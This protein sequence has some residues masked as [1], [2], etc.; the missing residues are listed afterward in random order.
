MTTQVVIYGRSHP[1]CP[2]CI[3]AKKMAEKAGLDFEYKDLTNKEWDIVSL[4]ASLGITVK[5]VPIVIID[6]EFIGGA[7]QL[8]QFIQGK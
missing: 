6:G 8:A 2:F 4:E 1:I 7:Q 3:Q 5:T